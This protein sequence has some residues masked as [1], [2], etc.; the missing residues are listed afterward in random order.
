MN[1]IHTII[2]S[3]MIMLAMSA[4]TEV[5]QKQESVGKLYLNIHSKMS[6]TKVA[7]QENS[8]EGYTGLWKDGESAKV[9]MEYNGGH[10]AVDGCVASVDSHWA[11]ISAAFDSSSQS[12]AY[13]YYSVI[14]SS[15]YC[16][17]N[18]DGIIS[19]YVP[20]EQSPTAHSFDAAASVLI[21]RSAT[22]ETQPGGD[23]NNPQDIDMSFRFA[24]AFGRFSL[25]GYPVDEPL[26]QINIIAENRALCGRAVLTSDGELSFV[27]EEK[28]IVI[29]ACD[30]DKYW[31]SAFPGEYDNWSVQ[32]LTERGVYT[33]S[34]SKK[35]VLEAGNVAEFSVDMAGATFAEHIPVRYNKSLTPTTDAGYV[36]AY[37]GASIE[38][39]LVK[40]IW[41]W[42]ERGAQYIFDDVPAI[43]AYRLS[44][45]TYYWL[46]ENTSIG[47]SINGSAFESHTI[48][49][50]DRDG[51]GNYTV[52]IDDVFLVKGRN[53]IKITGGDYL[54]ADPNKNPWFPNI[55]TVTVSNE[56]I[57]P[58]LTLSKNSLEFP[59]TGG[60]E[61]VKAL[62]INSNEAISA[63]SSRPEHVSVTV[64]GNDVKV[65][66]LENTSYESLN[67]E[68]TVTA[69][70]LSQTLYIIQAAAPEPM[71]PYTATLV[72]GNED[73]EVFGG[74]DLVGTLI[75][76]ITYWTDRG[77]RYTFKN[78]PWAGNY[79][80]S[81]YTYF[82][83]DEDTTIGVIVNS[84][85]LIDCK[86]MMTDRDNG[87]DVYT[88]VLDDVYLYKGTNVI[89]VTKGSYIGSG[90]DQQPWYPNIGQ[91]TITNEL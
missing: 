35:L 24:T 42:N 4:C 12:D 74:A 59:Y 3:I 69:G 48:L 72:P 47:V 17:Y 26:L 52:V 44:I 56:H 63:I 76:G 21:G 85:E 83:I 50:T 22:F 86:I 62:L 14:P 90:V 34:I 29:N 40:G 68:I 43:G 91:I 58:Q 81:I 15:N 27:D 57:F 54:G 46:N 25:T 75:K 66:V 80:I 8:S 9:V 67:A 39:T 73:V 5:L 55:G 31:F 28:K 16:G 13:T 84:G 38:G 88:V 89:T 79:R 78:V 37:G 60:T 61:A 41:Y 18:G 23:V 45:G 11:T 87:A 6:P 2:L 20:S 33:K 53:T 7:V 70:D 51:A 64:E 19:V 82:W 36:S 49:T 65:T 71:V 10:Q 77:G 32:A 1:R 30:T